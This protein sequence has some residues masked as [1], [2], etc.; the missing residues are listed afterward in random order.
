MYIHIYTYMYIYMN[1]YMNIQMYIYVY[2]YICMYIY[3]Y[4]YIDIY[5]YI[6]TYT[7]IYEYLLFLLPTLSLFPGNP[8][9][10]IRMGR[11]A[12]IHN[13][14]HPF[15]RVVPEA[16]IAFASFNFPTQHAPPHTFDRSHVREFTPSHSPADTIQCDVA[17]ESI[18][19]HW[20]R[21]KW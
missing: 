10:C 18:N 12:P 4:K 14:Q 3:I 8:E 7:H 9:A 19:A 6:Y 15:L 17:A 5:I 11:G 20:H 16:R 21:G 2:V 1:I 13:P